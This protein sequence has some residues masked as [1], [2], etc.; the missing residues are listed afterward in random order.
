[1]TA[2]QKKKKNDSEHR[3]CVA[4]LQSWCAVCR[5]LSLLGLNVL[6]C[7]AVLRC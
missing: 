6:A 3:W 4:F 1:L 7:T 5:W 2:K